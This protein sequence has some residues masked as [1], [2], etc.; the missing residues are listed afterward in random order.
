MARVCARRAAGI[1]I[2]EYLHRHGY[3]GVKDNAYDRLA[4]FIASADIDDQLREVCSHFLLK[5]DYDH[6]LPGDPD[7]LSEVSWLEQAL[8]KDPKH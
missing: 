5:V 7:L 6:R 1:V 2:S 4:R 3:T 8:L